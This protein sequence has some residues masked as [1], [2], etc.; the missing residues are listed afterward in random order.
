MLKERAKS[1][2][3]QVGVAVQPHETG[4]RRRPDEAETISI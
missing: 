3:Q 4:Q 1:Y 2:R